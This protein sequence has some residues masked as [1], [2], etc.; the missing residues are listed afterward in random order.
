MARFK[1]IIES[2]LSIFM[3]SDEFAD[4]H[5]VD[6]RDVALIIDNDRLMDRSKKEF[7]GISIGEILY[8]AKVSDF[9]K[10]PKINSPQT[11]DGRLMYIFDVR[12]NDGMYEVILQQNRSD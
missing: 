11:F 10:K 8:Y 7:D 2:D 9:E 4:I 1:D 6:G 3:N 12:E 5:K